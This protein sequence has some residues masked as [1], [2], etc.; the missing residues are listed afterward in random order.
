MMDYDYDISPEDEDFYPD[1]YPDNY[2]LAD[3]DKSS[4]WSTNDELPPMSV[5]QLYYSCVYPTINDGVNHILKSLAW[6]IIYRVTV[7][8]GK[9][10]NEYFKFKPPNN[11]FFS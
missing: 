2:A 10:V 11:L 7:R 9:L 4:P 5:Y 6:C 1:F 8:T 3:D